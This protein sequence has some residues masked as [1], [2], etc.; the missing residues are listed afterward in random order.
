LPWR[1]SARPGQA[2]PAPQRALAIVP[3]PLAAIRV[4]QPLI[5]A[6]DTE[7]RLLLQSDRAKRALV[8]TRGSS[9]AD[10]VAGGGLAA[11]GITQEE[12]PGAP[13]PDDRSVT[14]AI[15]ATRTVG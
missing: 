4:G 12:E 7:H 9:S 1:R 14:N 6:V 5:V 3:N 2:R 10:Q 15:T 8:Q 11:C 13:L